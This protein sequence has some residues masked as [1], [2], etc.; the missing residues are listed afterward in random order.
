MGCGALGRTLGAR[1]LAAGHPLTVFDLERAAAGPLI[2]AGASWAGSPAELASNSDLTISC[3][4]GP[5]DVEAVALGTSG[6]WST[7]A[8]RSIHVESSTVG[9]ACVRA[10]A[11]E[12]SRRGIRFIDAPVSRGTVRDGSSPEIVFWVG[13][14]P[15]H[16]DMAKT[17]LER[18]GEQVVYCGGVGLGQITKIVNNLIAHILIVSLGEALA[19]G[20]NAG[21][22]LDM[23]SSA[24]Q[25]GTAQNRLLDEL[26]PLSV[27]QGDFRP[28]LRLDVALKDLDLAS[29]LAREQQLDLTLFGPAR[30]L[31]EAARR[32]GWG[33]QSAHAVV[34]L[35]EE[36]SG[37]RLR[38]LLADLPGDGR[39]EE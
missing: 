14:L 19:L 35:I 2:D 29:E 10:L 25:Y 24:L 18:L 31:F 3:L 28:G 39:A 16:F 8:P 38:S 32:R 37:V 34:R 13:A 15:D 4:P 30:E 36:R 11:C 20:V 1:V 12:A 17:V 22:S 5:R 7:A 21:A 33:E 9:P 27:F 26:F 6:L 23:L